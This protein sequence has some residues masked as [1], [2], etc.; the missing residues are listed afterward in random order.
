MYIQY[1][2]IPKVMGNMLGAGHYRQG[3]V[4]IT[5]LLKSLIDHLNYWYKHF[6]LIMTV[7]LLLRRK[8]EYVLYCFRYTN[9]RLHFMEVSWKSIG[10]CRPVE[11]IVILLLFYIW[12]Q[13]QQSMGCH[14]S[15]L[16]HAKC[17][18]ISWYKKCNYLYFVRYEESQLHASIYQLQVKLLGADKSTVIS[19][20]SV[21][22]SEDLSNYSHNWKEVS[23]WL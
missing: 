15:T 23:H 2:Y 17:E 7:L 4:S 14:L 20:H 18:M 16:I 12:Q 5:Y 9:T 8:K 10:D 19:E 11:S 21:N 6:H 1:I 3:Q 13:W 22:P